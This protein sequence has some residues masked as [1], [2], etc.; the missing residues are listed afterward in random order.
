MKIVILSNSK[1]PVGGVERFSS[2]LR[3]GLQARGHEVVILGV[4]DIGGLSTR[5]L[6]VARRIGLAVPLLGLLLGRMA[7]REGF[8]VCATNGMLGWNLRNLPLVNV[9]HG[10]F[11]RSAERVYR[12]RNLFK[13]LIMRFVWGGFEGLAAR[14][15][16]RCVAVSQETRESVTVYYRVPKVQVIYNAVD[17]GLFAPLD[18]ASCRARHR[19][20]ADRFVAL[21]VGRFEYAKGGEI[22]E[23]LR[24]R[25]EASGGMLIVAERYS[26]AELAELCSAAD[27]FLLPSLHEG[28]AYVLLEAM[29]AGLPFL[30]SPVGL[31]PELKRAGLFPECIVDEQ[32]P[33]AYWDRMSLLRGLSPDSRAEMSR[34]LRAYVLARHDLSGAIAQYVNLVEEVHGTYTGQRV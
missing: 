2:Y 11:A 10:T 4:E 9:Q 1:E 28:C 6:A 21:F 27:V 20:P 13:Y 25:L 8:D 17:T 7:V 23:P 19:I 32:T 3:D 26:Q 24:E 12:G 18:R 15:A 33:E 30:A 22:L 29:S 14:R 31:V 16:T 5:L 34:Q